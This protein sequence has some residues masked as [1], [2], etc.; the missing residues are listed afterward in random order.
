MYEVDNVI[1]EK[2]QGRNG[3]ADERQHSRHEFFQSIGFRERDNGR[4]VRVSLR[5]K[6]SIAVERRGGLLRC[7]RNDAQTDSPEIV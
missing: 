7:A 1:L 5:A 3:D 4:F 2:R 6:R